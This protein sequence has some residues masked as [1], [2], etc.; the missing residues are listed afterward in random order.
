MIDYDPEKK[1]F[2]DK[3]PMKTSR[4]EQ[5]MEFFNYLDRFSIPKYCPKC[6][7]YND[8]LNIQSCDFIDWDE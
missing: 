2:A 4:C 7:D 5:C 3:N 8:W 6:E 1:E